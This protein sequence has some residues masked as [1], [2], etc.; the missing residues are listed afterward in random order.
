[1]D[2][3]VDVNG[4][5]NLFNHK[6]SKIPLKFGRVTGSFYCQRN[7]L[8][9]L[10]GCPKVVGGSFYCHNNKLTSLLGCP[11]EVPGSFW[12]YKN[13]LT[14]LLGCPGEVG[15]NFA[16][17]HNQLTSL[18]GCPREVGGEFYC[19]YNPLPQEIMDNPKSFL[20]QINR[21]ILIN[22]LIDEY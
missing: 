10:E 14:T 21:D 12:C 9:T 15:L 11:G 6:L 16:C 22:K 20:K 19:Y 4:D 13:K 18:E 8:T 5:V 1:L 17:S 7:K 2:G 3:T